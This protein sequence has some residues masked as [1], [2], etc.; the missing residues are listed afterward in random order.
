[1]PDRLVHGR[2]EGDET[3]RVSVAAE[4]IPRHDAVVGTVGRNQ[5]EAP[6]PGHADREEREGGQAS[7][8]EIEPI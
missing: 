6:R 7:D 5:G 4:K 1:M 8:G 3:L 2:V